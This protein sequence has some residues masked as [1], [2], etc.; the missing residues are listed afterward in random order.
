ME[1]GGGGANKITIVAADV[2]GH[3]GSVKEK[4][5]DRLEGGEKNYEDKYV[6]TGSVDA[7]K[8]NGNGKEYLT[9]LERHEMFVR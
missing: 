7:E 4:E 5:V 9:F 3:F 2:N 1:I 6:H 8:E